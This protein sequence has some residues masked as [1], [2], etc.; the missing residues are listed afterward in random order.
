MRRRSLLGS[1][2]ALASAVAGCTSFQS[3]DGPSTPETA[4]TTESDTAAM[5]D[6]GGETDLDLRE[7]N[8]TDV[9]ITD[10]G[11]GEYRFSV[12]IYHDDDGEDGFANRWQ[13]ETLGG[14]QLG[15]RELRHAHSTEP[16]TRSKTITIPDGVD[17]VAVRGHDQTHGYG[18]LAMLVGI[19]D[20]AITTVGNGSERR[21][22]EA[23]DCP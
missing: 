20:G 6:S 3:S 4:T 13:V 7:A 16:F 23:S 10:Q 8:V 18:G 11:G 2:L 9:A 19:P 14:E 21:A 5:T 1:A 22:F 17:C 15:R 12:E